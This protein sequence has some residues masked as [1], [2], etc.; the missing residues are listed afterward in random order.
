MANDMMLLELL[1]ERNMHSRQGGTAV[2]KAPAKRGKATS[3]P[4]RT[5]SFL[6]SQFSSLPSRVIED[7]A[8]T[9]IVC[10]QV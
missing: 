9:H 2:A 5:S 10:H 7:F 1:L 6:I 4:T 8:L 3:Q